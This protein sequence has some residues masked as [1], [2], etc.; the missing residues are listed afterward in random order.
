MLNL[1]QA[2][3][4]FL[5]SVNKIDSIFERVFAKVS[6]SFS[7]LILFTHNIN[8]GWSHFQVARAGGEREKLFWPDSQHQGE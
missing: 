8:F 6:L 5:A 3:L 2:K 7:P 1:S 4:E